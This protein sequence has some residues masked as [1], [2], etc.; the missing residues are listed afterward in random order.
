M[1]LKKNSTN[2]HDTPGRHGCNEL[3]IGTL[4]RQWWL[5][6]AIPALGK[7]AGESPV[8]EDTQ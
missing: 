8:F 6:P 3:K 1:L 4:N 2:F 7:L 5:M